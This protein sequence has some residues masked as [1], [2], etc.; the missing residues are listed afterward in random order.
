M[1]H[2]FLGVILPLNTPMTQVRSTV[3]RLIAPYDERIEVDPYKQ[4]LPADH[5]EGMARHYGCDPN[6]PHTCVPHLED[7]TGQPGGVDEEG[8]FVWSRYNPRSRWDWFEIGGRWC[9]EI[10]SVECG[11]EPAV[12]PGTL[13]AGDGSHL[14]HNVI[15]V[16]KLDPS[17]GFFAL[18]TPEGEWYE[19]GRMGW[20][21][22]VAE[23][24]PGKDWQAIR[25]EVLS[26]YP[27]HSIVGVDCHI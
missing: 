5:V 17:V 25:S 6:D 19:R 12:T 21:G 26:A 1:S 24:K 4:K 9:G 10:C 3:E 13:G 11:E 27:E 22:M 20:F 14:E 18:C 8:L 23:E 16:R 7:W 2:F 15:R